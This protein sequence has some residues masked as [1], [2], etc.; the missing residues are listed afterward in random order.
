M[1]GLLRTGVYRAGP[2]WPLL[3]M[4]VLVPSAL[5]TALLL[6]TLAG[7]GDW[8]EMSGAARIVALA[9]LVA[10]GAIVYFGACYLCG[11]RLRDLTLRV[12][13]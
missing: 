7:W 12:P 13:S 1:R 11:L 5:M 10:A 4:R 9:K 8:L 2:G 3:A 6:L